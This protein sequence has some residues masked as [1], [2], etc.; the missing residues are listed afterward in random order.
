MEDINRIAWGVVFFL[1]AMTFVWMEWQD[2]NWS[3][4]GWFLLTS[5]WSAVCGIGYTV[6]HWLMTR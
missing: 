6:V 3:P 2:D 4:M 1:G 5:L